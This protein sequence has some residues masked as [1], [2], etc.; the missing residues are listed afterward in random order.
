MAIEHHHMPTT[1]NCSGGNL[2][3]LRENGR[4]GSLEISG[5]KVVNCS[6]GNLQALRENGR[7][8]SLEISGMKV[9]NCSGGNLQAQ[10]TEKI[11]HTHTRRCLVSIETTP[12]KKKK[13]LRRFCHRKLYQNCHVM[14]GQGN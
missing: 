14:D 10:P 5:T 3:A 4:E 2:Q 13:N 11:T 9:M 8:G 12:E 1:M 7:E 6:G